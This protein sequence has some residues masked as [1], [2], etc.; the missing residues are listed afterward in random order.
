MIKC[1]IGTFARSATTMHLKG[2]NTV[3]TFYRGNSNFDI[4]PNARNYLYYLPCPSLPSL[5]VRQSS[6]KIDGTSVPKAEE[7]K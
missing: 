1:I 6:K 5:T 7:K 4:I 3:I 2:K